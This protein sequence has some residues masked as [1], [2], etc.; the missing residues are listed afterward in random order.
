MFAKL[1]LVFALAAAQ[2]AAHAQQGYPSKSITFVIPAPPG[3][4]VDAVS[5][6]LAEEMGRRMGRTIVVDNRPGASGMLAPQAV[7]RA[8]ADGYTLLVTHGAPILNVPFIVSKV[9]Y[10]VRRD[11]AFISQICTGTLVLVVHPSVP[12][13]DLPAF[14][15]WAA[16]NKGK[17]TYG[18]FGAGGGG[19][20]ASAYLNQSRNL[21]MTH[22]AYK[23]EAPMV[24]D[25]IGGQVQWG[26]ATPGAV[27]PHLKSGRIRALALIGDRR[28]QELPDLPTMAELGFTEAELKPYGWIGLMAPAGVPAPILERL[29]VEA[30]EALQSPAMKARLLAFG[31]EPVGSTA[32]EFRGAV[33]AALPVIQR[34]VEVSG[35]KAD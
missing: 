31:L 18:S 26:F 33:D 30:R 14:L 13:A 2:F 11:L 22:V 4:A 1:M 35:V 9:P 32:A 6:V 7:A 8:P 19:H 34:M 24:Q 29:G 3:G 16:R 12:A 25:L 15:E 20:L 28:V 17:V 5:R 10:D 27:T 21:G 23:G